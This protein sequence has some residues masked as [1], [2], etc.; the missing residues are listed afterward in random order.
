MQIDTHTSVADVMAVRIRTARKKRKLTQEELGQPVFTHSY[1]SALERGF[2]RPSPKALEYMAARLEMSLSYFTMGAEWEI[3]PDQLNGTLTRQGMEALQQDLEYQYNFARM[4]IRQGYKSSIT[5]AFSVIQL[6]EDYASPYRNKLPARLLYR[7]HFLRGLAF[8]QCSD[9]ERARPELEKAQEQASADQSVLIIVQNMLGVAHYL[10]G[11]AST[12]LHLHLQCLYGMEIRRVKDL[13]LRLSI[14]NNLANDY[15]ALRDIT[16]AIAVYKQALS[17]VN[18]LNGTDR[19]ASLLWALAV[20]YR[21]ADDRAH[22]T[23]YAARAL[24]LYES[25]DDKAGAASVCLHLGEI[26]IEDGRFDD[27]ERIL[28]KAG[29]LLHEI[30]D[31]ILLTTLYSDYAALSHR[32]GDLDRAV[33]YAVDGVSIIREV[34]GREQ[35]EEDAHARI[36]SPPINVLSAY[37]EVLHVSAL[38]EKERGNHAAARKLFEEAMALLVGTDLADLVHTIALSYGDALSEWGEHELAAKRYRLAA[39]SRSREMSSSH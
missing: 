18:D 22:A 23:L 30:R 9:P 36:A 14:L 35:S 20:S 6:A 21:A 11:Q 32:K 3:D 26:F 13:S 34:V 31:P 28:D 8:L 19:Q 10:L 4:M 24:Q 27:A 38:I 7:P 12:A 15:W 2:I 33:G 16:Q 5:D 17:M 25:L 39:E 1:I 37:A 29:R